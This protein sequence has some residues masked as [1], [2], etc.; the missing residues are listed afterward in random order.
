MKTF[1]Q[2]SNFEFG[3]YILN[4]RV[5]PIASSPNLTLPSTVP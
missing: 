3:L 2:Y 4:F 1:S 5:D